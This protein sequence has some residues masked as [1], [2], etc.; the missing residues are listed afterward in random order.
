[1]TE[2]RTGAIILAAGKSDEMNE[3]KPMMKLGKT[4]MIQRAIDVLRQAGVTPIIV[5]TGYQAD[6]LER[7]IA[8]R[9]AV[10]VRNKKYETSQMFDSICLGL[11]KI[12]KK[13]DQ[14]LLFPAD[15]PLI[16][17][18]TIQKMKE[19]GAEIAVPLYEG[20]CGHPVLLSREIIP[21][22]L[23]YHGDKGLRGAIERCTGRLEKIELN[24]AGVLLNT[25]TEEDY[26]ELLRYETESREQIPLSFT[27]QPKLCRTEECFDQSTADFL[28]AVEE[29]G[30]MLSAC[31]MQGISYSKAWKMVKLAEEQLGITF[32]ARQTGGNG[33]GSSSLTEEGRC[34]V[35]RYRLFAERIQSAGE[36]IFK[37]IFQREEGQTADHEQGGLS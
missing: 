16:S 34:F 12:G 2:K 1:M 7:H 37:E 20:K 21:S 36:D 13:T 19:S 30:S 11:R 6:A 33:G 23:T 35:S 9:G 4:T 10:C 32:L 17:V 27:L 15:V 3:L 26:E 22:I 25:N 5:V 24:D 29:C 28:H 18:D 31:Q 8:H 14:V